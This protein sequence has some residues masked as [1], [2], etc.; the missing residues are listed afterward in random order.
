MKRQ[1]LAQV[2]TM[3]S[4]QTH[5]ETTGKFTLKTPPSEKMPALVS[6]QQRDLSNTDLHIE[7]HSLSTDLIHRRK[8]ISIMKVRIK[9]ILITFL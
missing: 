4:W 1:Q 7:K 3:Q 5:N 9:K 8:P 2:I 6:G